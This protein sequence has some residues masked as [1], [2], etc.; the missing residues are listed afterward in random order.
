MPCSAVSPVLQNRL[1]QGCLLCVRWVP[2]LLWLSCTCLSPVIRS[3]F[4]C[5]LWTGFGPC[6]VSG[7]SVATLALSWV[8]SYAY[9]Q[10]VWPELQSHQT[11][12]HCPCVIPLE[13]FSGGRGLQ[14]DQL[15]VFSSLLGQPSDSPPLGEGVTWTGAGSSQ[16]CLQN[17]TCQALLWSD[18]CQLGWAGW[19]RSMKES[20][21]GRRF[22]NL[23]RGA[24][25]RRQVESVHAASPAGFP[26]CPGI[27]LEGRGDKW[28]QPALLFLENA[29][30]CPCPPPLGDIEISK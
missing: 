8:R 19:G 13:D 3:G 6:D 17:E 4:L 21:Q 1:L 18:L 28:Y 25:L 24:G 22:E 29:P 7:P 26:G 30:K 9:P 2:L 16:G 20:G 11:A 12:G 27:W 10:P 14:S 5:L 15:S 23:G